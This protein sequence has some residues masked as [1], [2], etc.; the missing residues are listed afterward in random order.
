MECRHRRREEMRAV[1]DLLVH[2]DDKMVLHG[3]DAALNLS[4]LD[5]CRNADA[6]RQE[7]RAPRA[8]APPLTTGTRARGPNADALPQG[9]RPPRDAAVR[10]RVDAL[11]EE[12][13]QT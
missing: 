11:R 7:V 9:S 3:A 12:L 5:E 4:N 10:A 6:L 2:A 1:A 8:P 13:A